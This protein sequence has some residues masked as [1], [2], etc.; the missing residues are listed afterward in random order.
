LP[1]T[2]FLVISLYL[3]IIYVQNYVLFIEKSPLSFAKEGN[4][5]YYSYLEL[6]RWL[7]NIFTVKRHI[8]DTSVMNQP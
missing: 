6:V 4:T 1:S 7:E 8:N 2:A 5:Q 3:F